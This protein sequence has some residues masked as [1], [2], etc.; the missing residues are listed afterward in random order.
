MM[1]YPKKILKITNKQNEKVWGQDG[2]KQRNTPG[3]D[4]MN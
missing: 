2:I 3:G 4:V 1:V